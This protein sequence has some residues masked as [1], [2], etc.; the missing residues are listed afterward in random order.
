MKKSV[1]LCEAYD[2]SVKSLATEETQYMKS[3]ITEKEQEQ[4]YHNIIPK[5]L[6]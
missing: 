1:D 2:T 4:H 5:A 6:I 3:T